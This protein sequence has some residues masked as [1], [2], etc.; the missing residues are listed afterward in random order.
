MKS[1]GLISSISIPLISGYGLG[2]LRVSSDQELKTGL[3]T[4]KT[5]TSR[6]KQTGVTTI[7]LNVAG[8]IPSL[9]ARK[10][11]TFHIFAS[12][13]EGKEQLRL[14]NLFHINSL[15]V[16]KGDMIAVNFYDVDLDPARQERHSFTIGDPYKVDI[17]IAFAE[18]GDVTLTA[19][20]QTVNQYYSK[21][22][23]PLLAGQVLALPQ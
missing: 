12:E 17:D 22:H 2:I 7:V 21:N 18:N 1:T 6:K 19:N 14:E 10:V 4:I 13:I 15:A 23:Q 20:N 11:K 16:E 5:Q 3:S 9:I 8:P